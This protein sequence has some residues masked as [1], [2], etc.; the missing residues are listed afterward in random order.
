MLGISEYFEELAPGE[1]VVINEG[2]TPDSGDIPS[3]TN[4]AD[5]VA[6]TYREDRVSDEDSVTVTV[7]RPV[8]P[9]S[10]NPG[11]SVTIEPDAELV[12]AGTDVTFTM[13]VTNTGNTRLNNVDV[14]N[15]DL[16]FSTT[17]P[18][19]YVGDSETFTVVRTMT[20]TGEFDYTV[21][22]QGTSPQVVSVSDDDITTVVVFEEEIPENP[23]EEPIP[24]DT[25][26]NPQTGA[27]PAGAM[28]VSGLLTL[29]AG[30][31]ALIKRKKED[32]E[33]E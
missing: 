17:I 27:L 7:T 11:I 2:Y 20:N 8:I 19:L 31:F 25:V 30:I 32:D 23:P 14:T 22:A 18:V 1:T 15:T 24:G 33:E 26:E 4:T 12:E 3:V 29:G 9:P 28:T 13:V 16:E 10:Y 6:Y 21:V 5:V